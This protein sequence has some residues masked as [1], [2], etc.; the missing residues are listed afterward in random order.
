V[1]HKPQEELITSL[2][3]AKSKI[4]LNSAYSH[5]KNPDKHYKVIGFVITEAT[6]E[7]GDIPGA[8]WSR[9]NFCAACIGLAGKN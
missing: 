6:D 2:K 8:G 7:I 5:Y 9:I 1:W 4:K 3:L